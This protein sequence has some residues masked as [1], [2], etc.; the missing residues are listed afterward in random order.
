MPVHS[1]VTT[2]SASI[3]EYEVPSAETATEIGAASAAGAAGAAGAA[4][5]IGTHSLPSHLYF[6]CYKLKI[7]QENN[8]PRI[9]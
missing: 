8:Y 9:I 5:S 2:S 1:S 6:P 3:Q 7:M 4:A